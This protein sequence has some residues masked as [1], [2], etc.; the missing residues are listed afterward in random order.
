MYLIIAEKRS[1]AEKVGSCIKGESFKKG[2][3]FIQSQNYYI[4]W[5]AGHLYTLLDLEE[6]DP[7]YDPNEKHKWTMDGLPFCPPRFRYKVSQPKGNASMCATVRKQTK[8]IKKLAND[9][10]V[11]AIYH[12]GDSDREGEVIVRNA[13]RALLKS[14]KPI[15]RIWLNSYTTESVM[16]ALSAKEPDSNYDGWDNAGLARAHEDWLFG[17]NG[18][19]YLSL[20]SGV[21]LP[22][23][24]CKYIITKAIVD[25]ERAIT[26]FVPVDYFAVVSKTNVKG[27]DIELTSKKTF[28]KDSSPDAA[29]LAS[30]YNAAGA[31]VTSV[32]KDRVTVNPGRLFSTTELQAFVSSHYK[33][34]DP[35]EIEASLEELYQSGYTTYPRTN[36]SF[37]TASDEHD[38]DL[39]IN[40]LKRAGFQNLVN[41]PKKKSIYDDSKVDGHSA[42]TPTSNIPDISKLSPAQKITYECI[43]NRFLAVFCSEDCLADK[44]VITIRCDD[45]D[46]QL[47][48]TINVAK[49]W[50]QYEPFGQKD[51]EVP[52]LNDGESVPVDF[53]PV[54]KQTAPPKRFT[55]AS[56]GAWCN[57]PWRNEDDS[58]KTDYTDEEWKRILHE[59]TICTD[60][61]R[62]PTIT[63]CR[64]V[65]Y[66]KL[67][68]G[69]Y[70]PD[71][72]GYQF[73]DACEKLGLTFTVKEVM[74][75][76]M[77]L[78][79]VRKGTRTIDECVKTA[80]E[81]LN[82]MFTHKNAEVEN[83]RPENTPICKCPKCGGNIIEWKESYSC[84]NKGCP[85][86]VWKHS[87]VLEKINGKKKTFS[88]KDAITLFSGKPVSDKGCVSQKTGKTYDC[89]LYLDLT[90]EKAQMKITFDSAASTGKSVG[91]CPVC[92]KKMVERP[93]SFSCEN[94]SCGFTIWKETKRFSDI[95]K[96]NAE[97]AKQL[98]DGKGVPFELTNKKNEKYTTNLLLT[99]SVYNGK[100]YPKFD[101]PV[102]PPKNY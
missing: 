18:T 94:S 86:V 61:T 62:T 75:L 90:G 66:I 37:L 24:R 20:K 99:V 35:K 54:K 76:S 44:T 92:G 63:E 11:S 79:D 48:G 34:T 36:S 69:T 25:R 83:L 1:A 6:Y 98:L 26:N 30:R 19:R 3:G 31:R 28:D 58:E 32:K 55:V 87:K 64:N 22:W 49:G 50:L 101:L 7:N 13:V 71:T 100:H 10:S 15:Y 4:T 52:P 80:M 21:L 78:F 45:E 23:G 41:K 91:V 77:M 59:A 8:V 84:S 57:A 46:F 33:G 68:K 82:L 27:Y 65:G 95:L 88:K 67:S 53:K 102:K 42:L 89:L 43:R 29:A 47:T 17:I 56:F 96:I 93:N 40:A 14:N 38:V 2:D 85:A 39:A 16:K 70:S 73:V 72:K 81:K 60:A 5:C 9:A 97:K 51:K 74:D 12:C